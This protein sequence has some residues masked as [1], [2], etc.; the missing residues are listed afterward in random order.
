MVA[1]GGSVTAAGQARHSLV[2]AKSRRVA[3]SLLSP[4]PP[5]RYAVAHLPEAQFPG[6]G[7]PVPEAQ[8]DVDAAAG[9]FPPFGGEP[10]AAEPAM[11]SESPAMI[12]EPPAMHSEPV[13]PGA[14]QARRWSGRTTAIAA[15]VA[16][17]VSSIGAVA[18]AAATPNGITAPTD[19]R[20]GGRGGFGPGQGGI[21]GQQGQQGQP[22]QT[23]QG[24]GSGQQGQLPP[25]FDPSQGGAGQLPPGF[26]PRQ[27]GVGQFPPNVDPSQA[28]TG[29]R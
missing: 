2:T 6:A 19:Q 8:A 11:S 21:P 15:A 27:P 9:G 26:D 28:G 7:G 22:G 5:E 1:D 25:G 24:R 4:S 17:G 23:R 10:V 29:Q 12:S 16:L 20:G 18:A 3:P 13:D 14:P